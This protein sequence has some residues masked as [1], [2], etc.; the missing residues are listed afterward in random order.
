MPKINLDKVYK[1]LDKLPHEEIVPTYQLIKQ[2]LSAKLLSKST[3]YSE[4]A[5]KFIEMSNEVTK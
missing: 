5:E 3:E 1:E 4:L 2:F